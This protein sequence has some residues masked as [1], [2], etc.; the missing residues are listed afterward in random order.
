MPNLRSLPFDGAAN[1]R[2]LGG[3]PA[4]PGRQ[5]RWN[6]VYRSDS[7]SDL[8]EADLDRLS[9]LGL[10]GI[11]D[12]RLPEEAGK[13]PDRLPEGHQMQILNPGFL[14]EKTGDMLARLAE[15]SIDAAGIEVE[16]THHY[17]LFA[18]RH[19]AVYTP[20]F[21]MI[22]EADGQPV[23]IHCTSGKDRTGWGSALALLAAGCDD[24]TAVEDYL[25]TNAFRRDVSFMFPG[26]VDPAAL[27]MLTSAMPIYIDTALKE[28]RRL[29][30]P[31]NAWMAEAGLDEPERKHLRALLSEPAG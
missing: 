15:G 21:R 9:G 20:F 22:L 12:Y 4:G 30:G 19:I 16:V 18:R 14:P 8:T 23:L 2:D 13:K 7:L 10:F 28:L 11:C 6:R 31:R 26:G 1:F 17:R 29:H 24:A 5:T 25:L 27:H 3:Y